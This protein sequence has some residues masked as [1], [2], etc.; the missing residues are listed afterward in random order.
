MHFYTQVAY[1]ESTTLPLF[2]DIVQSSL[3]PGVKL[4]VHPHF[5][6]YT[7]VRFIPDFSLKEVK[8]QLDELM[9]GR[10]KK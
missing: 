1:P 8:T 7:E 3:P 2:I 5:R 6:E 4:K 9:S 10:K